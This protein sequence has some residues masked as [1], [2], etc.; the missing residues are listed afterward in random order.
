MKPYGTALL[1]REMAKIIRQRRAPMHARILLK[2]IRAAIEK[3]Q[4]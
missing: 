4:G 3:E 2:A 1:H